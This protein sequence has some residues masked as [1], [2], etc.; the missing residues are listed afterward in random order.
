MNKAIK[1]SGPGQKDGLSRPQWSA[2]SFVVAERIRC[3]SQSKFLVWYEKGG[4]FDKSHSGVENQQLLLEDGI[5]YFANSSFRTSTFSFI[6]FP[7]KRKIELYIK[8]QV[9]AGRSRKV[10]VELLSMIYPSLLVL[11]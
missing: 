8:L 9:L 2:I 10:P 11:T 7:R 5:V 6:C 4:G 1:E 3:H